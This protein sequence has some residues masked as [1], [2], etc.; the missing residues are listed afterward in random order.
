MH[1]YMEPAENTLSLFGTDGEKGLSASMVEENRKKYGENT[2]TK[3]KKISLGRRVFEAACEPM[4]L[5]LIAAAVITLAVNI[6]RAITGGEADFL[7]CVG[8]FA[9]ISPFG[10]HHG[11]DGRAKREG[12]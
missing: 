10:H 1:P 8:I 7:E 4:I 3:E 6:A 2:F 5:M 12:V 11:G 9:A